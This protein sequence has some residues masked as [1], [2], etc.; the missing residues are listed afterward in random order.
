MTIDET[1]ASPLAATV[2]EQRAAI[3]QLRTELG[4]ERDAS[5]TAQ[6][7]IAALTSDLRVIAAELKSE[8]MN[9]SWCSEYGA[10]VD[11]VNNGTSEPWLEHCEFTWTARY[12]VAVTFT[13]R[14]QDDGEGY[15]R[16]ALD[17]ISSQIEV[18]TV[19]DVSITLTAVED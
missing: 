12:N 4:N 6:Q 16:A 9:R 19:D 2:E 15:V 1:T 13:G 14:D 3:R 17:E 5:A 7:R 18:V 8:A 11:R 10:Y